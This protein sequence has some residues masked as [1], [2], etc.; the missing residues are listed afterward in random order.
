MTDD[1]GKEFQKHFEDNPWTE[2]EKATD[3]VKRMVEL[4]DIIVKNNTEHSPKVI[5][6]SLFTV[7]CKQCLKYAKEDGGMETLERMGMC[8]GTLIGIGNFINLVEKLY[9]QS[10]E[11]HFKKEQL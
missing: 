4:L 3:E 5:I 1:L 2:H 7:Y 10:I 9:E 6:K 8:G 11:D